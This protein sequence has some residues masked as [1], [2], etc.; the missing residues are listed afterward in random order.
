MPPTDDRS[1][2]DSREDDR[3]PAL[4]AFFL[5]YV[6]QDFAVVYGSPSAAMDAF[7]C[8]AGN[9]DLFLLA[10]EWEDF[11]GGLQAAP[12][13]ERLDRLR[14]LG[15]AWTPDAWVDVEGLFARLEVALDES[16]D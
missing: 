6:N 4:E 7:I 9:E 2:D 1:G 5:G 11:S 16:G 13:F 15:C 12:L 10:Q 3:F 14:R 8:D